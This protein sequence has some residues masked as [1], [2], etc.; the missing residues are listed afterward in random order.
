MRLATLLLLLTACGASQADKDAKQAECDAKAKTIR[1]VAMQ[2][3]LPTEGVC[4]NPAAPELSK[5][6]DDLRQ[7]NAELASM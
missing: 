6:C 7:C 5:A 4:N 1:D 2:R 3:N